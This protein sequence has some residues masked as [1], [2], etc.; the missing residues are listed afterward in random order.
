[1]PDG[2]A[3]QMH[4]V[5]EKLSG[6]IGAVGPSDTQ[7]RGHRPATMSPKFLA[8]RCAGTA[9][10]SRACRSAHHSGD[11][12]LQLSAALVEQTWGQNGHIKKNFDLTET[13]VR[14]WVKQAERNAGTGDGAFLVNDLMTG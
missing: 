2:R 5:A 4:M 8:S 11:E 14:E 10:F 3:L 13:A 9:G 6:V 12:M 1:M 7:P